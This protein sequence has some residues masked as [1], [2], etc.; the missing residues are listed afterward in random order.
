MNT[1]KS[2]YFKEEKKGS[3]EER[4]EEKWKQEREEEGEGESVGRKKKEGKRGREE[5][6][7]K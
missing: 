1:I 3:R 2:W 4:G 7:K 6:D 5:G